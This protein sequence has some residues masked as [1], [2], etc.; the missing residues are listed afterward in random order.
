MLRV[1]DGVELFGLQP[2][3]LNALDIAVD[4][5]H[6]IAGND[7]WLTSARGDKHGAHSHHYKGLA[8]DLRRHHLT[9]PQVEK[10]R[11]HLKKQLGPNYQVILEKDHYHIEYDP[12]GIPV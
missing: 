11:L 4:V 6:D 10:V 5:F 7:C 9:F 3:M 1:K 2:E 12:E 8:I